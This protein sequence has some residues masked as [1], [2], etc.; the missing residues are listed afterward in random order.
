MGFTLCSSSSS[1]EF[2]KSGTNYFSRKYLIF[3]VQKLP[4][5][6]KILDKRVENNV[7]ISARRWTWHSGK[8]CR[9]WL[10]TVAVNVNA[11][12][13][14]L[15]TYSRPP[16]TD[17]MTSLYF[18]DYDENQSIWETG[19]M[20]MTSPHVRDPGAHHTTPTWSVHTLHPFALQPDKFE[21][22]SVPS[23]YART[24]LRDWDL[25]TSRLNFE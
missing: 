14:L 19:S 3:K 15:R 21:P 20:V 1:C 4:L 18:S 16:S 9:A 23:F 6:N 22:S 8:R 10:D 25:A 13:V 12:A 5:Y 17:H 24:G 11:T 2:Q 7:S